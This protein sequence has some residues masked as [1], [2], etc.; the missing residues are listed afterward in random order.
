MRR[1]ADLFVAICIPIV[2]VSAGAV[3]HWQFATSAATT[4]VIAAGVLLI[5]AALQWGL[6]RRAR[7]DA[8]QLGRQMLERARR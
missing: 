2:A 1:F 3:A 8:E 4:V 6:R 7:R 5:L